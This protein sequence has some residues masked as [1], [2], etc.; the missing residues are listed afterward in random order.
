MNKYITKSGQNIYDIALILYGSIEGVFDLLVSN[1]DISFD[2]IFS[3]GMEVYYHEDFVINQ[4]IVSWLETNNVNV[5]NG[6]CEISNIDVRSEIEQWI[7]E[8][9]NQ[10]RSSYINGTLKI[11]TTSDEQTALEIYDWDNPNEPLTT[12][13]NAVSNNSAISNSLTASTELTPISPQNNWQTQYIDKQDVASANSNWSFIET[14]T[15]VNLEKMDEENQ[16]INLNTMYSNGMIIVP[17][18]STEK[19]VYYN[20]AATPKLLIQQSGTNTAI[21]MQI[22]SNCFVAFDW[23]DNSSLDFYHYTDS[24]IKATH[25]YSDNGEHTIKMYGHTNF[26]NLDLSKVNGIYYALS[27]IY[28]NKDF[29]T[30]YPNEKTLNKLFITKN[31]Q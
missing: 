4:D 24:T 13:L 17:S 27:E 20:N 29:I 15:G 30:N 28:I 16:M 1:S 14:L 18:D 12:A 26:T 23:G 2:T 22:Y 6:Q 11:T 21:N 3:T 19:E 5:K 7:T 10:I 9:N 25:T 8:S 31:A